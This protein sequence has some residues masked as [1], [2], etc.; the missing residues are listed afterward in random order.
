[1]PDPLRAAL[2]EA[3]QDW[4]AE[5]LCAQTDPHLWCPDDGQTTRTAVTFCCRCP[6]MTR[7]LQY[8]LQRRERYG[9]WGGCTV[10]QRR[11]LLRRRVYRAA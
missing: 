6:V 3:R 11:E 8:A 9:V 5:G 10:R 1:M 4:M 2:A 7:C